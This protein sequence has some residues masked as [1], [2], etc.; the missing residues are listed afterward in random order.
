MM[1]EDK[2]D[3]Y[4][5]DVDDDKKDLP[6]VDI[7]FVKRQRAGYKS[8]ITKRRN[9]ARALMLTE[10]DKLC[11]SHWQVSCSTVEVHVNS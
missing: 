3:V 4:D 2:P 1:S 5:D 6:P 8:V 11:I 9:E 7:I 10:H